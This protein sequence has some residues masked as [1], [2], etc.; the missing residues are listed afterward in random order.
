M[1]SPV[2]PLELNNDEYIHLVK[3][4]LVKTRA[5][6]RARMYNTI[7]DVRVVDKESFVSGRILVRLVKMEI[8]FSKQTLYLPDIIL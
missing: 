6:S 2:I 4:M 5:S 3:L 7:Q 8:V 1:K